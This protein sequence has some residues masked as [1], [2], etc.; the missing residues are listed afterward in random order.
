MLKD[1]RIKQLNFKDWNRKLN[2]YKRDQRI[3]N[4]KLISIEINM[5][6]LMKSWQN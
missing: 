6:N 2:N 4:N 3:I 1:L 5:Q